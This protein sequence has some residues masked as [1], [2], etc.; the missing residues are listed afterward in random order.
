MFFIMYGLKT[1]IQVYACSHEALLICLISVPCP[2]KDSS[3]KLGSRGLSLEVAGSLSVEFLMA[4]CVSQEGR[5]ALLQYQAH[6][7]SNPGFE[8]LT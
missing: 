7:L 5:A 2:F 6:L 3:L 4:I 1:N 8:V